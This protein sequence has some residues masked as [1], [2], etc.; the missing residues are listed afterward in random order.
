MAGSGPGQA[1]LIIERVCVPSFSLSSVFPSGKRD[2]I[3]RLDLT[4]RPGS[5][6]RVGS[7]KGEKPLFPS[8]SGVTQVQATLL[9]PPL[10]PNPWLACSGGTWGWKSQLPAP[11]CPRR[12]QLGI[13]SLGKTARPS[14]KQPG[15]PLAPPQKALKIKQQFPQG[16]GRGVSL[17]SPSTSTCPLSFRS[18]WPD[19]IPQK[20]E[21]GCTLYVAGLKEAWEHSMCLVNTC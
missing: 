11:S 13:P 21:T 9:P 8:F 17:P 6:P 15:L 1:K 18:T 19:D 2:A 5:L 14:C 10:G 4:V 16:R 20:A 12:H 7:G 3:W